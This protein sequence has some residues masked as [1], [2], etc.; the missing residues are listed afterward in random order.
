MPRSLHTLTAAAVVLLT[1]SCGTREE[2]APAD[3]SQQSGVTYSDAP[4]VAPAPARPEA[5]L[6]RQAKV[7]ETSAAADQAGAVGA[8]A[9]G[10]EVTLTAQAAAPPAPPTFGPP[11]ILTN[12]ANA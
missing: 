7:A 1:A 5:D 4:T 11:Q 2:S 3:G 9:G 12:S 10:R 8:A 6:R